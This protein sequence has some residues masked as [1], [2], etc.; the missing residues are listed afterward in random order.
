MDQNLV[1]MIKVSL[2]ALAHSGTTFEYLENF[3]QGVLQNYSNLRCSTINLTP[4]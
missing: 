3:S 4:S 2:R 1:F